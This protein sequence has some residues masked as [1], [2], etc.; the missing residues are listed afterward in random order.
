[1][2][3]KNQKNSINLH[4]ILINFFFK[5]GHPAKM[6]KIINNTF[7][8]LSKKLN[9]PVNRIL[10]KV[11]LFLYSYLE[12]K[13]V[14]MRRRFNVVPFSVRSSR[15][16]FLVLKKIR[17]SLKKK[18]SFSKSLYLEILNILSKRSRSKELKDINI[19]QAFSNRSK[20]HFRWFF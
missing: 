14:R 20:T 3:Q 9:Q 15:R 2:E 6:K 13:Q 7:F 5:K 18:V 11:F 10:L 8:I 4:S 17:I 12:V 19:S 1:M 16:C